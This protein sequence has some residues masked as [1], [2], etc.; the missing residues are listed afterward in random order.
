[1]LALEMSPWAEQRAGPS[2][3][4]CSPH[5]PPTPRGNSG[6][7]SPLQEAEDPCNPAHFLMDPKNE[8][9]VFV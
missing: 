2:P 1:M 3:W 6:L 9:V 5:P 7:S 4:G 8:D